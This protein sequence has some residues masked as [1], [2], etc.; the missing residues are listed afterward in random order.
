MEIYHY[1]TFINLS[2]AEI[3]KFIVVLSIASCVN[4]ETL[5][6]KKSTDPDVI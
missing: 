1:N 5:K 6:K 3:N 2:F 4:S